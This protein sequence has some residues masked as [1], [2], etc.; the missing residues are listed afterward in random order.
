[1]LDPSVSVPAMFS[2]PISAIPLLVDDTG[3]C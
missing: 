1:L 2:T 3:H